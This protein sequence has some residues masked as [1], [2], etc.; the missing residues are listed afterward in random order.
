MTTD[1]LRQYIR[2]RRRQLGLGKQIKAAQQLVDVIVSC[3]AY[4]CSK[5]IALYLPNDGELDCRPL[6]RRA[7]RDGKR[8][9]LP[10]LSEGI[11]MSFSLY[12][13]GTELVSNRYKILEPAS[14][15]I[16]APQK[17]DLVIV[18]LVAFDR[19]ANRIG[20]GGGYYDRAFAFHQAEVGKPYLLGVAHQL[21]YVDSIQPQSWDV[22]L[23]DV[24]S[25]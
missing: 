11:S 12:Q 21:Q 15:A 19:Q 3:P 20:M 16:I 13:A 14:K 18:P 24:I 8:C 22:A 10:V 7:W 25:V 23:D 17:L 6:I 1:N 2:Q 4:R 5:S 9:Y